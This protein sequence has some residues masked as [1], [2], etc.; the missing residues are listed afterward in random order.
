MNINP[1]ERNMLF[2]SEH[3]P[4][5]SGAKNESGT[6]NK[7]KNKTTMRTLIRSTLFTSLFFFALLSGLQ[8]QDKYEYAKMT[9]VQNTLG[10]PKRFFITIAKENAPLEIIKLNKEDISKESYEDYL[11]SSPFLKQLRKMLDEGWE[12]FQ[13]EGSGYGDH[14]YLRRK[15]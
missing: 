1:V 13:L 14:A 10:Q 12:V 15:K 3:S 8:A 4:A 11:D 2:R 6:K 7:T 5:K 9:Y